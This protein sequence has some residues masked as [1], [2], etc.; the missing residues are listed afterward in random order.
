MITSRSFGCR[1]THSISVRSARMAVTWFFQLV[2]F[3]FVFN[4]WMVTGTCTLNPCRFPEQQPSGVV[5]PRVCVAWLHLQLW[6]C[7]VQ[8]SKCWRIAE[9]RWLQCGCHWRPV[10]A[11]NHVCNCKFPMGTGAIV[12]GAWDFEACAFQFQ[13][14]A[15]HVR[16]FFASWPSLSP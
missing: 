12:D 2:F 8:V 5:L 14:C 4:A 10:Q 3:A 11:D 13:V 6:C 1:C 9:Y 15:L 16:S 7:G